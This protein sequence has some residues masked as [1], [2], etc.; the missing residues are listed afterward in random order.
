MADRNKEIARH[1]SAEELDEAINEAQ[2]ADKV[3]SSAG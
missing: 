2:Q 3:G 1:L